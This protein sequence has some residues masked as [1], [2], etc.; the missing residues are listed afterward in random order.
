M[1]I[2]LLSLTVFVGQEFRKGLPGWLWLEVS[3][4][5]VVRRSLKLGQQEA[6]APGGWWGILLSS[7]N[8]RASP[9]ALSARATLGFEMCWQP[10]D[11]RTICMQLKASRV[12]SPKRE[13][14]AE[15]PFTNQ[16][17]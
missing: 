15:S 3:H 14:E 2:I 8:L 1:L 10:Q 4:A 7:W 6:E 9:F 17:Q 13:M 11:S 12:S 16:L 5:V